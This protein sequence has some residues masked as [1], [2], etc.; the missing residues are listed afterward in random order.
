MIKENTKSQFCVYKQLYIELTFSLFILIFIPSALYY[1]YL[2]LMAGQL[3]LNVFVFIKLFLL[4]FSL[5]T[6]MLLF[7]YQN[8]PRLCIS[9]DGLR[10]A[11]I[12]PLSGF[13][14]FSYSVQEY[15]WDQIVTI[16]LQLERAGRGRDFVFY[17][18]LADGS[19]LRLPL[20]LLDDIPDTLTTMQQYHQVTISDS[21]RIVV[22]RSWILIKFF[23]M[24]FMI[25]IISALFFLCVGFIDVILLKTHFFIQKSA[26][27]C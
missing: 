12:A 19:S 16:S 14:Y 9:P 6:V 7:Y 3:Q 20:S 10:Y 11:K 17:F 18:N 27:L 23:R 24:L 1:D 26:S 2:D 15:R 13:F 4:L 25:L 22:Q 5:R 21:D 8:R